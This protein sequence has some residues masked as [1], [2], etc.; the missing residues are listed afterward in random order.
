MSRIAARGRALRSR[1]RS[2]SEQPHPDLIKLTPEDRRYLTSLYDDRTPLPAGA[3]EEL[4]PENP[5]L[6]ALQ[7]AYADL[8]LPGA[9]SSRWDTAAVESFLDLRYFRGESLIT[10]HYRELPRITALKYFV[11]VGYVQDRDPEGLLKVLDEDG[12]FGCWTFSYPGYGRFSRDLLESVNEICFLERELRLTQRERFSV[13]D[14]GAG[15]GRMAHRMTSAYPQLDDY[16]CIDAIPESTFVSEYYL[17]YRGCMPRARV[18]RLDAFDQELRPGG[19][20]LA[21]NIHSFSECPYPAATWWIDQLKR[22]RVPRLLIVPNE[23][24]EMLTL[25]PDGSRRDF[26]PLLEAAGYRLTQCEPVIDDP[27]IQELL[28]LRDHFHLFD[29]QD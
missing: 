27:A 24:K 20:D 25:E 1:L 23:P 5:R 16:C 10:W 8:D 14:I 15:Y 4:S 2:K 13:L 6:R 12:A 9:T 17:R 18:V 11:F 26:K 7:E 21:L 3:E 19:F 29:L 22:L 28:Q